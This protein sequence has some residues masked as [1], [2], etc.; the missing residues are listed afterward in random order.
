MLAKLTQLA[1]IMVTKESAFLTIKKAA[2][3]ASV[4]RDMRANHVV[5]NKQ[6]TNCMINTNKHKSRFKITENSNQLTNEMPPEIFC[7]RARRGIN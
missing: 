2:R 4:L 6:S 1:R 5:S 3:Y 7:R